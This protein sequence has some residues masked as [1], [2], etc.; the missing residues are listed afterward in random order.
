[1]GDLAF[2]AVKV[3]LTDA[4]GQAEDGSLQQA[5]HT[6]AVST[7][8]ADGSLHGLLHGGVQHGKA[9][10]FVGQGFHLCGQRSGI[11]QRKAGV[12]DTRTG[13]DMGGDV[14]TARLSAPA[15][16]HRRPRGRR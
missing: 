16:R 9:L 8:G 1:M 14:D 15:R 13:G 7:G 4:G 5:A 10:R 2:H 3:R 11:V 12:G 6:V